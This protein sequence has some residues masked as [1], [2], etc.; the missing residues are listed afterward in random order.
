MFDILV[1]IP[2]VSYV[3]D[4]TERFPYLERGYGFH[5]CKYMHIFQLSMFYVW[6]PLDVLSG[7]VIHQWG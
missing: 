7:I 3:V 1:Q 4:A 6:A 2:W 5:I